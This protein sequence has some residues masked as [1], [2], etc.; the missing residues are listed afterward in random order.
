MKNNIIKYGLNM[1]TALL[2]GGVGGGFLCSC[3][4]MFEP[5]EENT[6]QLEAMVQETNYVYGLL[7]Y[8][9][10]RLPYMTKTET[11]C[12]TRQTVNKHLLL[13]SGTLS[14]V[15]LIDILEE[16]IDIL[17]TILTLIPT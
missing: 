11:E 2:L 8:G 9:Y 14:P 4:D 6:K 16:E 13:G 5:T 7:I 17:N 10:D 15:H 3:Q 1:V 12:L